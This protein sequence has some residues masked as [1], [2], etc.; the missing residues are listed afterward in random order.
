MLMLAKKKKEA[1][2]EEVKMNELEVD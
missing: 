1:E 2:A